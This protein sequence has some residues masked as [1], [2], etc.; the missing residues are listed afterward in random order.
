M[1][2]WRKG[3]RLAAPLVRVVS[4]VSQWSPAG[5]IFP[6][7]HRRTVSG[8]ISPERALPPQLP[9][10]LLTAPQLQHTTAAPG[11]R[12]TGIDC[13]VRLSAAAAV[14]ILSHA[15][16]VALKIVT[17]WNY[18]SHSPTGLKDPLFWL[19]TFYFNPLVSI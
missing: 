15:R 11:N 9:Q 19:T 16:D 8:T 18:V 4:N 6:L 2:A 17:T 12:A 1:H 7:N 14:F 13:F 3:R 10:S 5:S